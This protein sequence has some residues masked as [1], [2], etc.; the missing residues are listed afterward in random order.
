MPTP[1][2]YL[3]LPSFK[4]KRKIIVNKEAYFQNISQ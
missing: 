3:S 4:F 1:V 2:M